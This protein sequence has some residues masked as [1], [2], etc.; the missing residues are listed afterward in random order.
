MKGL[1]AKVFHS[2]STWREK[3]LVDFMLA[4]TILC[5]SLLRLVNVGIDVAVEKDWW[6]W[7]RV[8]QTRLQSL[9]IMSC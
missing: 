7:A 9:V 5:G 4:L 2:D 8:I 3:V 1:P 6:V